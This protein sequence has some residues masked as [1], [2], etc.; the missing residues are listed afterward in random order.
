MRL[1][2]AASLAFLVRFA[3]VAVAAFWLVG[4]TSIAKQERIAS[5]RIRLTINPAEV[6]GCQNKG[7][8]TGISQ[9]GFT[10]LHGGEWLADE[11][12]RRG[13]NTFLLPPTGIVAQRGI[14]GSGEVYLCPVPDSKDK[15]TR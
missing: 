4:C 13:G 14:F 2:A 6:A 3:L 9:Y 12:S 11:V 1:T 7:H 5:E 15:T 10:V 8:I